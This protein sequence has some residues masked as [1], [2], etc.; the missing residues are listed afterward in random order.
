M[1]DP[2]VIILRGLPGAGKSTYAEAYEDPFV[3]SADNFPGLYDENMQIDFSKLGRAHEWC[4]RKFCL[5]LDKAVGYRDCEWA[6]G[7]VPTEIVVDNT[8]VKISELAPY[9]AYA[10][11][12]RMHVYIV[13]VQS[14]AS[15]EALAS[16]NTH[17]VPLKTIERMKN[18]WEPSPYYMGKEIMVKTQ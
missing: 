3:V 13:H 11:R 4:F 8:N 17:N 12:H 16:R 2:T 18:S 5:A 6:A 9:Y 1:K 10:R 7:S 15:L 14:E